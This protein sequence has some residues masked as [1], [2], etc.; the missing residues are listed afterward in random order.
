[1]SL[2]PSLLFGRPPRD[3]YAAH[4]I[5]IFELLSI[6]NLVIGGWLAYLLKRYLD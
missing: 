5:R 4:M 2:E 3:E 6:L 1:M